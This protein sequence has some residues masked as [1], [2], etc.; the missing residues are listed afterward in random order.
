[1][2]LAHGWPKGHFE[3]LT[4]T[5]IDSAAPREKTRYILWDDDPP[6][7]GCRVFPNG[8]KSFVVQYRLKGTRK[9]VTLTLGQYGT[10]LTLTQARKVARDKLGQVKVGNDPQADVKARKAEEVAKSKMLTVAK[11]VAD[12][13]AALQ[14]GTVKTKRLR[15]RAPSPRYVE[16]TVLHLSRFA[17]AYGSQAAD[18]I[19]SA[20]VL[21]LLD[22]YSSLSVHR[23]MH[24]AIRRMYDWAR[25]RALVSNAPA[26]HIESTAAAARER[27]LTLA[28]LA[29]IWRAADGLE[30]VY[31]DVVHLLIATGQRRS[32]VAGMTW[33]EID[34]QKA[35]W[36]LPAGRTKARRQHTIPLPALAAAALQ[37]RHGASV[38]K[39][40]VVLPT[41]S[42]D[43]RTI[44]AIS[45]WNWLKRE[46]DRRTGM[47][48]WRL[49]DF[50]RSIVTLCA[51]AGADVAVLDSLL[52]HA[53]SATR[54]G[55]TGVYQRA[56]LI[57]PM[58][59]V[60][61]LWDRLLRDA[62]DPPPTAE[63]VPLHPVAA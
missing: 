34:L 27:V 54:G 55:V 13:T 16:D 36:T 60:M 47:T 40:D 18:A 35:I 57:E 10:H 5:M 37:A 20:D 46:L 53:S 48:D 12:Y 9:A 1:V 22:G 6:G 38:G 39:D 43:G 14:G 51:E 7:F 59:Q 32:E 41:L 56:T 26:D 3:L 30:A 33:G 15:Q 29:R 31:R 25:Q 4:K 62:L 63:V 50:R 49:H 19:T 44:A 2:W 24:G 28:E 11:L 42:R 58:R 8:L 52:N 21:R 45:G 17:D 23:R 61:A